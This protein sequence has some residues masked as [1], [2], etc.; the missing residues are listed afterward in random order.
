MYED[1]NVRELFQKLEEELTHIEAE[2]KETLEERDHLT[3]QLKLIRKRKRTKAKNLKSL[4]ESLGL[5]HSDDV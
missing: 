2:E 1:M 3:E 5:N 4:K